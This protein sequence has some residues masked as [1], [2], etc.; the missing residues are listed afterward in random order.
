MVDG[1]KVLV[2]L[3]VELLC[4]HALL[5]VG[6]VVDVDAAVLQDGHEGDFNAL[7]LLLLLRQFIQ[8]LGWLATK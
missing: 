5:V 4:I 8:V 2:D 7:L 6:P 1:D 3:F